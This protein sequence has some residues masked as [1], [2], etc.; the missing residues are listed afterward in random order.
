VPL[1][2]TENVT[3]KTAECSPR[4]AWPCPPTHPEL[5][6]RAVHVWLANLAHVPDDVVTLLSPSEHAR[7]ERFANDSDR[8]LWTR[9]HGVLRA[10]LGGYLRLDPTTLKFAVGAHGKPTLVGSP[11]GQPLSPQSA[12]LSPPQLSFNLSHSRTLALYAFAREG[13]VGVDVEVAR[14]PINELAIA[15]RVFGPERTRFLKRLEP[16]IREQEFLRAWVR[17]EAALKCLGTGIGGREAGGR[18]EVLWVTEIDAGWR[19]AA[20]VALEQ[21]PGELCYW[22]WAPQTTAR[23]G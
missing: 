13:A 15:A 19:V 18:R 6:G 12:G 17:H 21:P 8:Q 7:A 1:P 2:F 11:G 9:A 3:F 5:A 10:L 16:E 20:A 14:R 23:R 22:D 4:T